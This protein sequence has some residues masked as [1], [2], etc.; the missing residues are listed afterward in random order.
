MDRRTSV[1]ADE[2]RGGRSESRGRGR[3]KGMKVLTDA[4]GLGDGR[5]DV[6]EEGEDQHNWR[7]FRKGE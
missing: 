4:L 6:E 3:N 5:V 1:M 2:R 7:E